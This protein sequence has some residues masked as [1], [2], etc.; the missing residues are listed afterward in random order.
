MLSSEAST[1]QVKASIR[2]EVC[3]EAQTLSFF[4]ALQIEKN[5][6]TLEEKKN[7]K[8]S[9]F[10]SKKIIAGFLKNLSLL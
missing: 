5:N 3:P 4:L 7:L 8:K 10:N 9:I 1:H 6:Q 2:S